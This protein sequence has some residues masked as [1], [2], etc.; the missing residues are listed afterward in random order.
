M[1]NYNKTS[2]NARNYTVFSANDDIRSIFIPHDSARGESDFHIQTAL[3]ISNGFGPRASYIGGG[4]PKDPF[5]LKQQRMMT[6]MIQEQF[7]ENESE[8]APEM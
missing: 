3:N 2:G 6:A 4:R 8:R 1:Q 7:D 5:V